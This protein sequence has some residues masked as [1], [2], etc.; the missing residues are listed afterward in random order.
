MD[1][2]Y[3]LSDFSNKFIMCYWKSGVEIIYSFIKETKQANNN[4]KLGPIWL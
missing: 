2:E 4:K 1:L 3:D